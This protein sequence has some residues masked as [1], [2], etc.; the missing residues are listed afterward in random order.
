MGDEDKGNPRA[1][2]NVLQLI[3]H[4]LAQFEVERGKRLVEK[5][6][7]GFV[8]QR[9]RDGDPLLLT[10]RKRSHAAA[11]EAPQ[12]DQLQHCL[13]FLPDFAVLGFPDPQTERD[14]IE[15]VQ[16]RKQ[17]VFLE[18]RIDLPSVGGKVVD[19]FSV[20]I[21]ISCVGR[22]E[23]ADDTQSGCFAATGGTQQG[24]EF[25][26]MDLQMQ[27]VQNGFSVKRLRDT[28]QPDQHVFFHSA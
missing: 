27:V 16:V 21:H 13:D 15:H 12:V 2:L 26:V 9:T 14:V 3:L 10:A 11:F 19:P 18:N 17:R 7:F 5:Q 23:S 8:D 22:F 20:E 24:D 28:V 1:L 4:I 25:L 6:D